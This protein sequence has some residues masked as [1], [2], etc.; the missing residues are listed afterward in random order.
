[1]NTRNNKHLED[2]KKTL[3]FPSSAHYKFIKIFTNLST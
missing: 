1:M 3:W 2:F